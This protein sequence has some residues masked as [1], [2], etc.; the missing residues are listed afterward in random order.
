MCR[1]SRA[2]SN[3]RK[4]RREY[5]S[6]HR[7]KRIKSQLT[8]HAGDRVQEHRQEGCQVRGP[9]DADRN[10]SR[11]S[12]SMWP[13]LGRGDV[14]SSKNDQRVRSTKGLRYPRESV[15][16][17]RSFFRSK[18]IKSLV[19]KVLYSSLRAED[20][21]VLCA[22]IISHARALLF[23]VANSSSNDGCIM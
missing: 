21:L 11:R 22:R 23:H 17:L 18:S 1:L 14:A 20:T 7:R 13:F 12:P 4:G 2:R 10:E 16:L 5:G 9:R 3:C 8:E 15:S 6:I 19:E